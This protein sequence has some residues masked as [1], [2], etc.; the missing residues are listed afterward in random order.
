MHSIE[1]S[2]CG[3]IQQRRVCPTHG[4]LW[5][6][7]FSHHT[8]GA[9]AREQHPEHPRTHG[10]NHPQHGVAALRCG[11]GTGTISRCDFAVTSFGRPS[12]AY[13]IT[14]AA[15]PSF[16]TRR[17]SSSCTRVA[18]AAS[19]AAASSVL[20]AA[21]SSVAAV[22]AASSTTSRTAVSVV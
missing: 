11:G 20:H 6:G 5:G 19:S 10:A 2:N 8:V 15:V 1:L 9:L 17:A 16:A 14:A 22:A 12:T 18:A 3:A 4:F 21:S 7:L 13:A